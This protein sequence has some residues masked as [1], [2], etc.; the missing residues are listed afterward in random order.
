MF[1]L[2]V[3]YDWLCT[4]LLGSAGDDCLLGYGLVV[5]NALAGGFLWI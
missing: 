1:V 4:W 2:I 5:A 3:V